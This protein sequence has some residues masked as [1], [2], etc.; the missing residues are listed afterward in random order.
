MEK[1]SIFQFIL[2][3]SFGKMVGLSAGITILFFLMVFLILRI[4]TDHGEAFAVPEFFGLTENELDEVTKKR[5]LRFTIIDSVY[6]SQLPQGTVVDQYP[7]PGFMVKKDRMVFVTINA[8]GKEKVIM[9]NVQGVSFRQA[10]T[11]LENKGLKL[12]KISFVPDIAVNNVL[13]Q[14]LNGKLIEPGDTI[15]KNTKID[16]SIRR[17]A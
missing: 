2:S 5:D 6:L 11:I 3:K 9:P 16:F 10:R 17:R 15:Y 13:E 14:K 1:K 7:K 12:G 4:Y 8:Y